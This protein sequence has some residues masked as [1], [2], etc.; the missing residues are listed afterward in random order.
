MTDVFNGLDL[1][2]KDCPYFP[3]W[4]IHRFYPV[5]SRFDEKSCEIGK[6]HVESTRITDRL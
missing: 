3:T 2:T 6:I 4:L 5:E 1:D